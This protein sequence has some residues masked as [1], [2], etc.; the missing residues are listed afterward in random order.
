MV[1]L[2]VYMACADLKQMDSRVACCAFMSLWMSSRWFA[3]AIEAWTTDGR[4][5]PF[6]KQV[7]F[8]LSTMLGVVLVSGGYISGLICL[9]RLRP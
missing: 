8:S 6:P 4:L 1:N 3:H 5:S 9:W 7:Q 2:I